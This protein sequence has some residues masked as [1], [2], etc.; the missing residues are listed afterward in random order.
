MKKKVLIIHGHG[1]GSMGVG[2]MRAGL[3]I[4]ESAKSN[5]ELEV[6]MLDML[7]YVDSSLERTLE[8]CYR[9]TILHC[10][11]LWAIAYCQSD[12][13]RFGKIWSKFQTAFN[14]KHLKKEFVDTIKE[15]APDVV[16]C[17]FW[18]P[19]EIISFY[20]ESGVIDPNAFRICGIITDYY[21]NRLWI[22]PNID[23]HFVANELC[24]TRLINEGIAADKIRITGIPILKI[25][26]GRGDRNAICAKMGL[27]SGEF[28]LSV[29][30][31][32]FGAGRIKKIFL[33][34]ISLDLPVQII[35]TTGQNKKLKS[36]LEK[37][38]AEIRLKSMKP[39]IFGFVDRIEDLY[40]VSD[41]IVSKSGGISV[42]EIMAM[43]CPMVIMDP[44][45]GQEEHN[46]DYLVGNNAALFAR[47]PEELGKIINNLLHEPEKLK[48]LAENV[49][50]IA[51][52]DA[53]NDIVREALAA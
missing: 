43:G 3:A 26:T 16:I 33:K 6:K 46:R 52:P 41:L 36:E 27:K 35:V 7:K 44:I 38:T 5:P 48:K 28:I 45:P 9:Q 32:G 51:R 21:P 4:E 31:G 20:R 53:A 47:N 17:P 1:G 13:R 15:F 11:M 24:K 18:I 40:N 23:R 19:L 49:R 30:G 8:L 2:H 42:S 39:Q 14:L 37:I 29:L 25:F 22:Y 50:R 10:P 12:T 34:L